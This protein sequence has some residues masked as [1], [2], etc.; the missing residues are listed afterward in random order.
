MY[1]CDNKDLQSLV[2]D[3]INFIFNRLDEELANPLSDI[4]HLEPLQIGK[5]II[6]NI[7]LVFYKLVVNVEDIGVDNTGT[8]KNFLCQVNS[9]ALQA[10]KLL[11]NNIDCDKTR[12]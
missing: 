5:S 12:H 6:L 10:F 1:T 9:E 2:S 4:N 7:L 3:S 8:F 11:Q